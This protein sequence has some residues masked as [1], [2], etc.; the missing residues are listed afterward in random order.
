[1]AAQTLFSELALAKMTRVLG[2]DRAQDLMRTTLA[3]IQL[4]NLH[5]AD[6]L[7]RFARSLEG[8]GAFEGAVGALLGVQAVMR[9]AKEV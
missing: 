9:G 3:E 6:D 5:T 7:L 2:A 4:S 8:R 1:M